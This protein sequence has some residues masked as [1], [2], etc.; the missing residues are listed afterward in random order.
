MR[1][2]EFDEN[3]I[4]AQVQAFVRRCHDLLDVCNGQIQFARRS[5][6]Q[7]LPLPRFGGT[8]GPEIYKSLVDI[9]VCFF[10]MC[11]FNMQIECF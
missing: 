4:F 8:R 1:K 7:Q 5:N 6:G 9:Q 11:H 3:T 2:W 10:C